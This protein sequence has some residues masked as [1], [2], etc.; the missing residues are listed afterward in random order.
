MLVRGKFPP[1]QKDY[2]G[3]GESNLVLYYLLAWE[4][5]AEREKKWTAFMA[6]PEWQGYRRKVIETDEGAAHLGEV[7][8]VP[9][10]SPIAQSGLLFFDTLFD[11]NAACHI[12]FGKAYPPGV[13]GGSFLPQLQSPHWWYGPGGMSS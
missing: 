1:A 4:S 5:L 7:A 3:I 11:E 8:L 2:T 10:S 13:A 6:D 9:A 12:A